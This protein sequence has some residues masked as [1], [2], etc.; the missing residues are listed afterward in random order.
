VLHKGLPAE[1]NAGMLVRPEAASGTSLGVLASGVP[2]SE[3]SGAPRYGSVTPDPDP[4]PGTLL[5][6]F[7]PELQ[8]ATPIAS[9]TSKERVPEGRGLIEAKTVHNTSTTRAGGRIVASVGQNRHK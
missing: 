7:G 8:P 6:T 5:L 3:A 9:A 2:V 4:L 1:N